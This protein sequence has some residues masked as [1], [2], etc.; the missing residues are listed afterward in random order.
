MTNKIHL[1]HFDISAFAGISKTNAIV[2]HLGSNHYVQAT[3]DQGL[4]KTSFMNAIKACLSANIAS[5]AINS[6][7]NERNVT[8][9]FTGKDGL[10]YQVKITRATF[11]IENIV[12]T[13]DG[14]P[15]LDDKGRERKRTED[16]PV[17]LIKK[18]VGPLGINPMDLKSKTEQERIEWLQGFFS[19]GGTD[20]KE[21]EKRLKSEAK[22]AYDKRTA[23]NRDIRKNNSML[24]SNDYYNRQEYWI[25]EFKKIDTEAD[26]REKQR[27]GALKADQFIRAQEKLSQMQEK[28]KAIDKEMS[29]IEDEIEKLQISL[30]LKKSE[31]KKMDEDIEIGKNFLKENSG[32][33]EQKNAI[34]AELTHISTL[35][36]HQN[37]FNEI[38]SIVEQ[39]KNLT[40]ESHT[41]TQTCEKK[42][43]ELLDFTK[44]FTPDIPGLEVFVATE[45]NPKSGIYFNGRSIDE[46]SE[47]ELWEMS[48]LIWN[49][50][51]VQVV[52]IENISSLGSQFMDRLKWFVDNGGYV[53]ATQMDR[54]EKNI[55][56]SINTKID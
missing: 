30:S 48:L 28:R 13:P 55:K 40:D 26:L 7:S 44:S 31:S 56:I 50:F 43:K 6:E 34:D 16:K 24:A 49:K 21:K 51:D 33:A 45:E 9:R 52:F 53:F 42:T 25:S 41:L 10:L 39:T 23:V 8:A 1:K 17:A 18:L 5:N 22:S 29:D 36:I 14:N 11:S 35:K 54:A 32:I 4:N 3:G 46:M 2:I 20:F 19:D 12:T 37:Q 38:N 15:E 47:S 27:A